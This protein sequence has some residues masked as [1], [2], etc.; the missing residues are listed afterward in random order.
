MRYGDDMGAV[1]ERDTEAGQ[2]FRLRRGEVR[3]GAAPALPDADGLRVAVLHQAALTRPNDESCP[4][5]P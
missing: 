1:L 5:F 3:F 4:S 2:V